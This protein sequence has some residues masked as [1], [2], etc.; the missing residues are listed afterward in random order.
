[1]TILEEKIEKKCMWKRIAEHDE[2]KRE[3][4]REDWQLDESI[5]C[6]EC[7]GKDKNCKYYY[8]IKN[9]S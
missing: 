1:M 5:L 2:E 9:S 7:D 4:G 6:Y 3:K 8:V